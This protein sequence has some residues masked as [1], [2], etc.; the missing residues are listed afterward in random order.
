MV[1]AGCSLAVWEENL[2]ATAPEAERG[3]L[4]AV[5]DFLDPSRVEAREEL[6]EAD[7]EGAKSLRSPWSGKLHQAPI[8]AWLEAPYSDRLAASYEW[9]FSMRPAGY[10]GHRISNARPDALALLDCVDASAIPS[11]P[12]EDFAGF[13][14]VACAYMLGWRVEG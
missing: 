7:A 14:A 8:S 10:Y 3:D 4:A 11:R 1:L 9:A 2:D 13:A 5:L 6:A 12:A